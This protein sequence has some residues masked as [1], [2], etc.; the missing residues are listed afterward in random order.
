MKWAFH[1]QS[2]S[3]L[4]FLAEPWASILPPKGLLA[5]NHHQASGLRPRPEREEHSARISRANRD[6]LALF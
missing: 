2:A 1:E 3:I 4:W 6:H 5:P